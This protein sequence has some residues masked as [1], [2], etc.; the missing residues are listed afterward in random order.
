MFRYRY[1]FSDEWEEMCIVPVSDTVSRALE[2]DGFK[3]L[4]ASLRLQPPTQQ[5][6]EVYR[7]GRVVVHEGWWRCVRGGG[8][9]VHDGW[10][11]GGV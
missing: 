7:K 5:V 3:E 6:R 9:V 4:L 8:V 1:H 2:V 10:K 11:G